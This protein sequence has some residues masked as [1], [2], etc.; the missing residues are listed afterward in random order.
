[1]P[2]SQAHKDALAQGRRQSRAIKGYLGALGRRRPGRPVTRASVEQRIG[3]INAK[4]DA[5]DD[6]LDRVEL[7]Q[8]RLD[9][10]RTLSQLVETHD[11]EELEDGFVAHA[12]AYSERKGITYTAWRRAGVP[13][14]VLR[15][16]G[17]PR[18]GRS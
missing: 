7:I 2:M 8:A 12:K 14:A 15:R 11:L 6:P 5:T 18:R 13:A 9:A 3:R 4:L 16:A 1:M 10:E 17:I